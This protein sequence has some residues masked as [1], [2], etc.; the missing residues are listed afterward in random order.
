MLRNRA[1]LIALALAVAPGAASTGCA[2]A[3]YIGYR[4]APSYPRDET[5]TLDLVGLKQGVT[6]YLDAYG[7][8]HI[9]A[10]DEL[11]LARAL[12][13]IHARNR[14]FQMD[15]LRRVAR[16]RTAELV[17]RQK[18]LSGTTV[19]T[20]RIMRGWGIDADAKRDVEN[21]P[22]ELRAYIEA[23]TAGVNTGLQKFR[24]M[25]YGL[26]RVAPEPWTPAD[27]FALGRLIAWGIT[28]NWHQELSRFLMA[29]EA[30]YDKG[31]TF[32]PPVPW[33]G[34]RTLPPGGGAVT[35]GPAVVPEM[36]ALLRSAARTIGP[37]AARTG[38]TGYRD[39]AL[40]DGSNAW[41]LAGSRTASGKPIVAND[42]HLAHFLPG[43]MMQQHLKAP[44]LDVIGVTV[45]GLPVVL[46]GHNGKVAWAMTATVADVVDLYVEQPDP[47]D[48][49]RVKTPDGWAT[50]GTESVVLRVRDGDEMLEETVT[51]RTTP[52]GRVMNDFYT[53]LIPADAPPVALRWEATGNYASLD[54]FRRAARSESIEQFRDAIRNIVTPVTNWTVADASGRIGFAV[55]GRVPVRTKHAGTFPV[56]GWI[57][58][59]RWTKTIDA[60]ALPWGADP[61]DGFLINA[62]NVIRDA[63]GE[64]DNAWRQVDSAPGY[65]YD[66]IHQLLTAREKHDIDS[67]IAAQIDVLDLRAQRITPI[68]LADV[69]GLTDP[70]P[71]EQAAIAVLKAWDFRADPEAAGPSILYRTYREAVLTAMGDEMSE[72]AM[73]FVLSN[74]FAT[75]MVDGWFD[76][77]EHG[78]W[79]DR[80][81]PA[82]T[83]Q[84]GA[85][86]RAAFRRAVARLGD[87]LKRPDPAGW[88]WADVHRVHFKH[89]F[90][91]RSSVAGLVNLKPTPAPGAMDT[92][93]K[94]HH[95]IGD[96]DDPFRAMAGPVM[97]M[98]VDLGNPDG[99]RYVVETGASGWP[100]SPHYGDQN[101]LWL[102]GG[103]VPMLFDWAAV[104]AGAKA[105]LTLRPPALN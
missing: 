57:A 66:R 69:A 89:Y 97:R 39:N 80:R 16:G 55:A 102:S 41:A 45:P 71:A 19:D 56:P 54:A 12:G 84:R 98:V 2:A 10:A 48:P 50:M 3:S 81:T 53:G 30:G 64:G 91:S 44:G 8:P 40:L 58:D 104:R 68:V 96:A 87:E 95:D 11:D 51:I 79:D 23:Y 105:V 43:L 22:P 42:P 52:N 73:L 33:P 4:I 82:V 103:T 76:A 28:H 88:R 61:A 37:T 59:Y 62:N 15:M 29:W 85:A 75:T 63:S 67:T 99:G 5:K 26:L 17:G 100:G 101:P 90:G 77:P 60:A 46:A 72:R 1:A 27:S 32:W 14:F 36:E 6:V 93:W 35:P 13:Y 92:V 25:E 83:E 18:S 24:P 31:V 47:A 21:C 9:E 86:V 34:G 7:V 49:S 20:D 38:D 65:R 70:T 78:V 94:S 74:R